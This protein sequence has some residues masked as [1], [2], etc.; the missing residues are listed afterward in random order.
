MKDLRPIGIP[1]SII[2][3]NLFA[4]T[5]DATKLEEDTELVRQA[6]RDR[7]YFRANTDDPITHIRNEGGLSLFT[8]RPRTGQ[9][10]GY[11][12]P[13]WRKAGAIALPE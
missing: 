11:P 2:L 3:E 6:M 1:H 9:A 12:H 13:P 4:K 8:F 5:F 10:D 7:G